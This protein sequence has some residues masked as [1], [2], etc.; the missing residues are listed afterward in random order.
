MK[1]R[2]VLTIAG[3]D[4]GGGAGI[5]AD[6]KTFAAHGVHGMS[7]ITCVTAQNTESVTA[8][9]VLPSEIVREQ[10][11]VIAEDIGV[12]AV[13]TGMLYSSEII[14]AVA[15]ELRRLAVPVVVDP[16]A[17]AKSGARLLSESAV[18]TLVERL[19]PIT[20]VLTPN[21]YEAGLL[22]GMEI[23]DVESQKKAARMLVGMGARSAVVKGG[24]I[25]GENVVDVL[26]YA[27]RF[28]HL[29]S[30]RVPTSDT[31]GTG[32]VFASAIAARLAQGYEVDEAV[33]AAKDFVTESIKRALRLGR[34]HGPV[35]P[36]GGLFD[37]GERFRTLEKVRQALDMLTSSP[38]IAELIPESRSN[39]V[40]SIEGGESLDDVVGIPGRISRVG[41]KVKLVSEPW[42]SASNHV[43]RA[44]LAIMRHNPRIRSAINIR[45]GPDVLEVAHALGLSISMYDRSQEPEQVKKKEGMTIQWGVEQAV[46]SHGGVPDIIYHMG[47]WGKEA[48][49]LVTGYDAVDVVRKTLKIADK[50][51]KEASKTLT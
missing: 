43:A 5:Q 29:R 2:R 47:D 42:F 7:A 27:G 19:I 14:E 16:V 17:V 8:I 35:N 21:S 11:R 51:H 50:L 39:L 32:C 25:S 31:H 23:D 33:S 1:A 49:I 10:I 30:D 20:T 9:H 28:T 36:T 4:S 44:V 26:Y 12:D 41:D 48:M 13:K 24:H 37:N 38:Q 46:K 15:Y 6:L 34:G 22:T 45:Y 40:M 3:S 18:R